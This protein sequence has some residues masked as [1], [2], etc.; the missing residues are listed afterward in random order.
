MRL[1]QVVLTALLPLA[2]VTSALADE[3][4]PDDPTL[5]KPDLQAMQPTRVR[6]LIIPGP[7]YT[8]NDRLMIF[9]TTIAN[10]GDGP[11]ILNG[12][13]VDTEE[14]PQTEATQTVWRADGSSCTHIA[15]YFVF[16]PSHHHWHV[17]NF[18][19]YQLRKDDPVN[20]QIMG[21]ST[22]VSFCLR[23]D[24]RLKGFKG[25]KQV[26]SVCDQGTQG[27][28]TGYADVYRNFL[29]DQ[30]IDL[31]ADPN[32]PV[33]EGDYYLVNTPDPR[34]QFIEINDDPVASSGVIS[35]H[36]PPPPAPFGGPLRIL[37]HQ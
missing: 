26:K 17:D 11:L 27:I 9:T 14:G 24:H 15:G 18:G 5:L 36:V 32:N 25:K 12:Q 2:L 23:D 20:G 6:T 28:S 21:E 10:V 31:D 4:D 16:H 29:P 22:K 30:W 1:T 7:T 34:R 8:S 37:P 3:C 35:V 33:P 13:T 19:V